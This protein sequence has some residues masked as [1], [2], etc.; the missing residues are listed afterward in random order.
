MALGSFGLSRPRQAQPDCPVL[1]DRHA[2]LR[3][4]I[5][6]KSRK[7]DGRLSDKTCH[8]AS[9]RRP[10]TTCSRVALSSKITINHSFYGRAVRVSELWL[11]WLNCVVQKGKRK[12]QVFENKHLHFVWYPVDYLFSNQFM[13]DLGRIYQLRKYFP[14][15][16]DDV[17]Q[18][19]IPS[20]DDS[21]L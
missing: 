5:F 7:Q 16:N 15:F 13:E 20:S 8:T 9:A 10:D 6:L 18:S 2:R 17:C 21:G 19:S 12:M 3:P 4:G 14:S 1:Y 11:E